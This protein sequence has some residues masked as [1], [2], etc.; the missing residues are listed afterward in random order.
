MKAAYF[1]SLERPSVRPRRAPHGLT[2]VDPIVQT[3]FW[4]LKCETV[5]P[6][7]GC[8]LIDYSGGG[9]GIRRSRTPPPESQSGGLDYS[10]ARPALQKC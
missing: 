6:L 5:P 3:I 9:V 2:K 1:L 4:A 7:L 10:I 8:I